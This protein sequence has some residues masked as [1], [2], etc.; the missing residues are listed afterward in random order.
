MTERTRGV[1]YHPSTTDVVLGT[2][3]IQLTSANA[4][5]V[6][7]N[8][9]HVSYNTNQ[10]F[11]SEDD[12]TGFSFK[13]I[14]PFEGRRLYA[15]KE[16][17]KYQAWKLQN[18]TKVGFKPDKIGDKV[19]NPQ[20]GRFNQISNFVDMRTKDK[21]GKKG[22]EV[23]NN[24][25]VAK[26]TSKQT[27][28]FTTNDD[29]DSPQLKDIGLNAKTTGLY[30]I[31]IFRGN[32]LYGH[33]QIDFKAGRNGNQVDLFN[34][35]NFD[36]GTSY[37]DNNTT[38]RIELYRFDDVP[39]TRTHTTQVYANN[40]QGTCVIDGVIDEI[41]KKKDSKTKDDILKK[42][43]NL[44]K[45][46]PTG[47]SIEDIQ[48]KIC[49]TMKF[50]VKIYAPTMRK[51][52]TYNLMPKGDK[53]KYLLELRNT[54]PNHVQ[55]WNMDIYNMP[56]DHVVYE[57]QA[58]MVNRYKL[59]EHQNMEFIYKN[60]SRIQGNNPVCEIMTQN[61]LYKLEDPLMVDKDKLF[62]EYEDVFIPMR[63]TFEEY[64]TSMIKFIQQATYVNGM[65]S[66]NMDLTW[67]DSTF[68]QEHD[69]EKAYATFNRCRYYEDYGIPAI[70]TDFMECAGQDP[71]TIISKYGWTQINNIKC[72]LTINSHRLA[73]LQENYVY[74]NVELKC[75]Y[76]KGVRFD[77][78]NTAW[79]ITKRDFEFPDYMLEKID[80]PDFVKYKKDGTCIKQ[81]KYAIFIGML[82]QT[83]PNQRIMFR[84]SRD[85]DQSWLDNVANDDKSIRRIFHNEDLNTLIFEKEKNN[86]SS[87]NYISSYITAYV[88]TRM[89]DEIDK[90]NPADIFMVKS[91]AIKFRGDYEIPDGFKVKSKDI[92]L[93]DSNFCDFHNEK[94]V[95]TE[96]NTDEF[97]DLP[98]LVFL[99][100]QGGSGKTTKFIQ[101]KY[102]YC[103]LTFPTH[104]LKADKQNETKHGCYTHCSFFQLPVPTKE[105]EKEKIAHGLKNKK[106]YY[107]LRRVL[108][109]EVTMVKPQNLN[110]MIK[111]ALKYG[112]RLYVAGDI[113][114][115][116][117]TPY[118]LQPV[119]S[120]FKL[121]TSKW[122]EVQH[123]TNY[124]VKCERLMFILKFIRRL[125]QRN[126]HQ[127]NPDIIR[128]LNEVVF[129][130][131]K[132]RIIT[133]EE[134]LKQYNPR[135][136]I[137]IA[138]RWSAVNHF[139]EE[140]HKL[141]EG[142][143]KIQLTCNLKDYSKGQIMYKPDLTT[144]TK[145]F[146]IC[147]STTIHGVQ[148]KTFMGNLYIHKKNIFEYG[149]LY[150]A[151]SRV[152]HYK[153]IFIIE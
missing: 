22:F 107:T 34:A 140:L 83:T 12:G 77:V 151:L 144:T 148:G 74:P 55:A 53:H 14:V 28:N 136:D 56:K 78:I 84:Y 11:Q 129:E 44:K 15:G 147:F 127:V 52:P 119:M 5:D 103:A 90:Y 132:D 143:E 42:C 48:V 113:D 117:Q 72:D 24:R 137:I 1:K 3:E 76:D 97:E 45:K 6:G 91:D 133:E 120:K 92:W 106:D 67:K 31:K 86:I 54:A 73:T 139:N 66:F 40:I 141:H 104:E 105:E 115:K 126:T 108:V 47:M 114:W 64:P 35:F 65:C 101:K 37:L 41:S 152:R 8:V 30:F 27:Y 145:S 70:P 23:I 4:V 20:T 98:Q 60:S 124:R 43:A 122:H 10:I 69:V 96:W 79:S 150:T 25:V 75:L 110:L 61:K 111:H 80:H 16:T 121:D 71:L 131:I 128:Q 13:Q 18:M 58:E 50:N 38:Y 68:V 2:N 99:N 153:Q 88:R 7:T 29:A 62:E 32:T 59:C 109:D 81:S 87:Y 63:T 89:Y 21:K 93:S 57:S 39:F 142:K 26:P 116:T 100:G 149:M 19:I 112:Y 94:E 46:F 138:G 51:K 82:L 102:P 85:P 36:S 33:A 9:T 130:E 134:A 49:N 123:K 118:Q 125:M 17:K 135:D 146:K 95:L